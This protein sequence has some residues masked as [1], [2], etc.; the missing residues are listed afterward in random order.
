MGATIRHWQR[1]RRHNKLHR[2]HQPYLEN[3]LS[4]TLNSNAEHLSVS[5]EFLAFSRSPMESPNSSVDPP[6]TLQEWR[7]RKN[8]PKGLFPRHMWMPFETFFVDQGYM[9]WQPSQYMA[10]YVKPP[11]DEPRRQDE[12]ALRTMYNDIE[13]ISAPQFDMLVG[14]INFTLSTLHSEYFV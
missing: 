3:L 1:Q 9:L 8:Q 10:L 14:P 11:N 4:E 5:Q 6:Q 2:G 12:Y 7:N 13:P